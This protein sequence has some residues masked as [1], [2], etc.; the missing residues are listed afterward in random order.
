MK[1]AADLLLFNTTLNVYTENRFMDPFDNVKI[2]VGLNLSYPFEK[3]KSGMKAERI[4]HFQ[5]FENKIQNRSLITQIFPASFSF[6]KNRN[7]RYNNPHRWLMTR[8]WRLA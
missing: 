8:P 3:V 7:P 4:S 2:E 6:M 1:S 5:K